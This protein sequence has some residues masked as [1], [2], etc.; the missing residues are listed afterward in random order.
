MIKR[1]RETEVEII[2]VFQL[3]VLKLIDIFFSKLR[4]VVRAPSAVHTLNRTGNRFERTAK[5]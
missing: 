4:N 1:S 5:E 2:T 3:E